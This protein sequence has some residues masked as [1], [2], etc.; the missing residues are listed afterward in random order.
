MKTVTIDKQVIH[1]AFKPQVSVLLP[2][3]LNTAQV[4]R[5]RTGSFHFSYFQKC[6]TQRIIGNNLNDYFKVGCIDK[7]VS[8]FIYTHYNFK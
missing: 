4:K 2:F 1:T 3:S 7:N 5:K 6:A 8:R